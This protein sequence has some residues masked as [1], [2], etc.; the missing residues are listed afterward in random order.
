VTAIVDSFGRSVDVETVSGEDVYT[1]SG[2]SVAFPSGMPQASALASIE[3]MAPADYAPPASTTITFL[4]FIALFTATEQL[5]IITSS[6]PQIRLFVTMAAGA[7]GTLDLTD[8]RVIAGV[9]YLTTTAPP[10]L[11]ATNAAL[12]LSGQP[13]T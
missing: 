8:P 12:I 13:S 6:D 3:S 7:G 10:I 1:L 11:T 2:F 5:A 4:A 9:T